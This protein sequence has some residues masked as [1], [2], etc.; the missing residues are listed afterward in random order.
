MGPNPQ[1]ATEP[2]EASLDQLQSTPDVQRLREI[3]ETYQYW[4]KHM[5]AAEKKPKNLGDIKSSTSSALPIRA[6][7]PLPNSN[8]ID[9]QDLFTEKDM[10]FLKSRLDEIVSKGFR[11]KAKELNQILENCLAG[12]M[13]DIQ[14]FDPY[15]T[16]DE[17]GLHDEFCLLCDEDDLQDDYDIEEVQDELGHFYNQSGAAHHIEV[18]LNDGKHGPHDPNEPSCEFTFEYDGNGKLIPTSNNVEDKLRQYQL[19]AIKH[20]GVTPSKT[21]SKKKKKKKKRSSEQAKP[22]VPGTIDESLCL[23]CQYEA[24]YGE[25]PV[26]MMKWLEEKVSKEGERRKLLK[27][28]LQSVKQAATR[29]RGNEHDHHGYDHE[30][31]HNHNCDHDHGDEHGCH[32]DH[33]QE[34]HGENLDCSVNT[35]VDS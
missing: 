23:F 5:K 32:H 20:L 24:F 22:G 7:Q 8:Y 28:K 10:L 29:F 9:S 26:H 25:K 12:G 2:L 18:E 3:K 4:Q 35:V 14:G 19:E 13:Q 33:D 30:Y 21:S 27:E 6:G 34:D 15:G 1:L 31:D 16:K 17:E 11:P